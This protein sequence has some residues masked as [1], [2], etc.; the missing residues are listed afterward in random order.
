MIKGNLTWIP[1]VIENAE[2]YPLN[3]TTDNSS[4]TPNPAP[5][6]AGPNLSNPAPSGAGLPKLYSGLTWEITQSKTLLF[7]SGK[8]RIEQEG[9]YLES[10]QVTDYPQDFINYYTNQLTNLGFKQTFNSSD[11]NGTMITYAKDDLFL[12]FGV[13]NIFSGSGDN[14]K[15]T[16]YRAY[17]EHN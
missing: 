4:D 14:K 11:P 1:Y 17:I 2:I 12:T 15:I 3:L 8:R 5:D 9:V 6:G 16:G 10:S 7:T 13:K